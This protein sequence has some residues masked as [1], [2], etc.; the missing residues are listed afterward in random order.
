[1]VA[2]GG[3][4]TGIGAATARRLA[5]EGAKVAVGDINLDGAER[6]AVEIRD[7]GGTAIAVHYDQ[8][9]E[10]SCIGLVTQTV[11]H[12]GTLNLLH[13]NAVDTSLI[14]LDTD[15]LALDHDFWMRLLAA[16]LVGYALLIRAALPHLLEHGGGA[17][18]CTS[19]DACDKG[20]PFHPGY[21]AAKAGVNSL[22]R[23]VASRWGREGI[24]INGICPFAMTPTARDQMDQ[25][26]HDQILQESC[27]PRL[28]EP[29]DAAALV[30]F[31]LSDDASYV[32]GQ[33]VGVNGGMVFRG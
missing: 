11:D 17:I 12:F 24:R 4:A 25:A 33:I 8:A 6:T 26:L 18:V 19:S 9:D 32:N 22:V 10:A 1:V 15:L 27:S 23:H 14:L 2:V 31:L 13:A 29:E 7:A 16:D 30:A 5:D 28:G 21:A 3:A 20:L